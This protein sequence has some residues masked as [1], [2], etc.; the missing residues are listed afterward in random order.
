MYSSVKTNVIVVQR[1]ASHKTVNVGF[2]NRKKGQDVFSFPK[3][4]F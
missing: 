4:S 2:L 1:S 3:E